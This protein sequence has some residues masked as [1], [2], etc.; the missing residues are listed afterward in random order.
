MVLEKIAH[1]V[2]LKIPPDISHSVGAWSM[3]NLSSLA[4][5]RFVYEKRPSFFGTRIDNPIGMAAGFD[6]NGDYIDCIPKYGFGFIEVGSVTYHGGEGNKGKHLIRL[7]EKSLFNRCGLPGDPAY[8][9][10]DRL[11]RTKNKDYGVN[12]A[13][14]NDPRIQGIAAVRD[15]LSSYLLLG[16]LGI[17]TAIS[18]CPSAEN[19][20]FED[21]GAIE[22]LLKGINVIGKTKPLLIK[23]PLDIKTSKLVEIIKIAD[24][25][26]DG[27]ICGNTLPFS[28]EKYG[29]GGL[30]GE[31]VREPALKLVSKT[32]NLTDKPIIACGGISRGE[33]MIELEKAGANFFQVFTGFVFNGPHS[34]HQMNQEY[35]R[36]KYPAA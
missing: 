15:V 32:R 24:K 25:D 9:I 36:I 20:I 17:Y 16:N 8:I 11:R 34:I 7:E 29:R 27:Y 22:Y 12:I 18:Q 19:Q 3:K 30:S 35:I 23:L 2:L 33:H 26:V 21:P 5:G 14:T 1:K 10:A 28:H 4:P 13:P 31:A 6:K